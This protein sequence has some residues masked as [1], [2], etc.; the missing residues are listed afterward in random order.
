MAAMTAAETSVG[1][2]SGSYRAGDIAT[3]EFRCASCR[4]GIVVSH[5]LPTCPMCGGELWQPAAWRPFS[6]ADRLDL[7]LKAKATAETS[8]L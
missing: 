8:R 3:G 4:Y 2:S 7:D 5:A 1:R 6:R